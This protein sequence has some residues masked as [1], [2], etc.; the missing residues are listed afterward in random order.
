[1][2][3]AVTGP[4]EIPINNTHEY[5]I[6]TYYDNLEESQKNDLGKTFSYSVNR[7]NL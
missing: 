1:M 7:H 6:T 4:I 2:E 3:M 5:T